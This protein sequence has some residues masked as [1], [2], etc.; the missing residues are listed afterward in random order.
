MKIFKSKKKTIYIHIGFMK[1]GSSAIQSF[2]INNSLFLKENDLYFPDLNKKAM[3][4]LGFSLLDEIPPYVH[5]KLDITFKELYGNLKKEIIKSKEEN[6]IIS[7]EAYSLI[8]TD[9][10]LGDKAP[11]LLKELLEDNNFKFK[12]IATLRP[13]KSYLI[14]QYNQHIKTHNFYSLFHGDINKFYFEKKELF[15]FNTV[16]KRW[17]KVFGQEN[18]IL[19]VYNRNLD[20]VKEFLKIFNIDETVLNINNKG[21]I[22]AKM[23]VKGLQFMNLANKFGVIKNTAK[24]NYLL[25]DL[26]ENELPKSKEGLPIPVELINKVSEECYAG[27]LDLSNRYFEGNTDWFNEMDLDDLTLEI[28]T[29][30]IINIEEAIKIATS[31]WNHFQK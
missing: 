15:D 7:A 16:I 24:Q 27:N 3:N 25:V 8:S 10:F 19:N 21:D 30:N 1:T 20:S 6:I 11:F 31:I 26:I 5:H 23:S 22:N 29:D 4:Y 13:Q 2:L 9:S 14:S 18:I 28:N 12:I 17:E